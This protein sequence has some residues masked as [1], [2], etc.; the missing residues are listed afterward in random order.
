MSNKYSDPRNTRFFFGK[1]TPRVRP[2][3]GRPKLIRRLLLRRELLELHWPL[4]VLVGYFVHLNVL[5]ESTSLFT[6]VFC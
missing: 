5:S 6:V 2:A 4:G 3:I 1:G